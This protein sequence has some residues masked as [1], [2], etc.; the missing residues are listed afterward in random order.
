MYFISY[1]VHTSLLFVDE[2][3]KHALCWVSLKIKYV[4]ETLN[5]TFF[6]S[7][8]NFDKFRV[9]YSLYKNYINIEGSF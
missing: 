1:C 8:R 5:L 7:L 4:M 3:G 9:V 2:N 6:R